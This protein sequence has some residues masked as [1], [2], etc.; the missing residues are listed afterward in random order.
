VPPPKTTTLH[1]P[2]KEG[3]GWPV[4]E[5][6]RSTV[7]GLGSRVL[8]PPPCSLRSMNIHS[9]T[10]PLTLCY[11]TRPFFLQSGAHLLSLWQGYCTPPI[12]TLTSHSSDTSFLPPAIPC[13]RVNNPPDKHTH[14]HTLLL[15]SFIPHHTL[16]LANHPLPPRSIAIKQIC[17]HGLRVRASQMSSKI[18]SQVRQVA[19]EPVKSTL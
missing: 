2:Q 4:H 19:L 13:S 5:Q 14:D 3:H 12:H 6:T 11:P 18:W 10:L 9:L 7:Y 16:Q 8:P 15:R 17:C 1:R